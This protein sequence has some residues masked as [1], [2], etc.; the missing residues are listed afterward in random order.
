MMETKELFDKICDQ[1]G[2]EIAKH[3]NWLTDRNEVEGDEQDIDCEGE[4]YIG[5][6]TVYYDF[7]LTMYA[8]WEDDSFD[9]EFDTW[10]DPAPYYK[11]TGAEVWRVNGL[12]VCDENDNEIELG[13]DK[14]KLKGM[15]FYF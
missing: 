9:H 1:L 6:Y 12:T 3:C 14:D 8:E 2:D 10:E 11:A 15:T 4:L 5:E 13:F 7:E